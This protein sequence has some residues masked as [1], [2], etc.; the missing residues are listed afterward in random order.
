MG[1]K[2]SKT[3][4]RYREYVVGESMACDSSFSKIS[5][6]TLFFPY[7]S[8]RN[9]ELS[10]QSVKTIYERMGDDYSKELF[11]KRIALIN[12]AGSV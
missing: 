1:N 5:D 8:E 6:S 9:F 11:L 3:I 10:Y 2:N 12:L 4:C 7:K